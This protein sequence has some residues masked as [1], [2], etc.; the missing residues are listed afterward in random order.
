MARGTIL[1]VE[2]DPDILDMLALL[3]TDA[4]YHVDRCT[5]AEDAFFRAHR[6]HPDLVITHLWI[7]HNRDEGWTLLMAL[8]GSSDTAAIP[9][10]LYSGD[11]RTLRERRDVLRRARGL[12]LQKPFTVDT[13]TARVAEAL[14]L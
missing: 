8:R 7:G 1:V 2:D 6:L 13:L 5:D 11:E 14:A 10:I 9:V 12:T 3:L 4:G